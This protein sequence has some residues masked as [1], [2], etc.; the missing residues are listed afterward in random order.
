MTALLVCLPGAAPLAAASPEELADVAEGTRT[1]MS[2][3]EAFATSESHGLRA[4]LAAKSRVF[5][6]RYGEIWGR[7]GEIWRLLRAP[8]T[9]REACGGGMWDVEAVCLLCCRRTS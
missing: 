9:H 2:L 5:Y 8:L 4:A 3:G 6:V 1:F 7:Y